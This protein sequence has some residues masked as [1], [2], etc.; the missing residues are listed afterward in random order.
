[1]EEK[2]KR[3][4]IEQIFELDD[5]ELQNQEVEGLSESFDD[6]HDET[7]T[8]VRN[9]ERENSDEENRKCNKQAS[10]LF[11]AKKWTA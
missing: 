10:Y 11:K 6:N 2:V 1:M 8:T 4:Q 7:T 9:G 5:Q 3:R